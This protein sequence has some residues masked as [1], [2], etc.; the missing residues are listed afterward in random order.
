MQKAEMTKKN[1][2]RLPHPDNNIST[3]KAHFI[4]T[5]HTIYF[6]CQNETARPFLLTHSPHFPLSGMPDLHKVFI[7]CLTQQPPSAFLWCWSLLPA[8]PWGF[9]ILKHSLPPLPTPPA[10]QCCRSLGLQWAQKC[11]ACCG[12]KGLHEITIVLVRPSRVKTVD[13]SVA[14]QIT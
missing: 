10:R 13:H 6:Q 2:R 4:K 9:L 11:T 8:I 12:P 7:S 14:G 1:W 5:E 3:A